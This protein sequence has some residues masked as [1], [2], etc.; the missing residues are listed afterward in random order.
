[1]AVHF[2]GMVRFMDDVLAA[3]STY[4]VPVIEDAAH[5]FPAW[6]DNGRSAGT[7]GKAAV[8]SFYATKTLTTAEGGMVVTSDPACAQ[9]VRLLRCHG[10]DRPVWNRYRD[11]GASWRYNVAQAGYKYNMSDILAALGRVQL[12]RAWELLRE[13]Q[14]IAGLYDSA[15]A[16]DSRLLLPPTGAGDARHL[17][18]LRLASA[19]R[20]AFCARRRDAFCAR[21]QACG[22]GISV[23]FIPLHTMTFYRKRYGLT[24]DAFPHTMDSFSREL[25]LPIWP[26]MTDSEIERVIEAVKQ[27]L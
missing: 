14:R 18:P 2:G 25:S 17:Y 3:A 15:F 22:I 9:T 4:N 27:C 10:I 7:L 8:F 16:G 20:D 24:D 11:P 6:D 12:S 13:R 21:I 23:H 5:A 26:G 19:G 1:V